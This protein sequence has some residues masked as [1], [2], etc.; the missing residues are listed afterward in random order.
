MGETPF[1]GLGVTDLPELNDLLLKSGQV[2]LRIASS[3]MAPT[4]RPGDEVAVDPARMEEIQIGDLVLFEQRG[5]L[6]CHRLVEKSAAWLTR[7]DAGGGPGERIR[8]EQVL[9]KVL[10][11]RKRPPWRG[12]KESLQDALLPASLRW[13]PRVQRLALYRAV[14][15]PVVAPFLSYHL[16]LAE[17]S[18]WY[19]WQELGWATGVPALPPSARP[20]LVL[21]RRRTVVAGWTFVIW[22]DADWQRADAYVR[23]R[24]RGLRVERDLAR[25]VGR[26]V[27]GQ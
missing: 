25:M 13:L 19:R 16:G 7:G 9:G 8:P 22:K 20:H 4:L 2:R 11:I 24:Y 18:R 6:I 23:I 5:Q 21:A 27:A 10:S 15:R 26:L 3:S 1:D 17:G 14:M 12:L